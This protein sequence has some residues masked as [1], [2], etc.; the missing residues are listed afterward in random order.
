MYNVAYLICIFII[1][2]NYDNFT[3]RYTV[4]IEIGPM[5]IFLVRK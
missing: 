2:G 3:K 5:K 1:D 4:K